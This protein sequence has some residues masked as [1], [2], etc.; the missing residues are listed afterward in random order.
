M[1]GEHAVIHSDHLN[2]MDMLFMY[3][4]MFDECQEMTELFV[5]CKNLQIHAAAQCVEFFFFFFGLR[6]CFSQAAVTKKPSQ[7]ITA[8]RLSHSLSSVFQPWINK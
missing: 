7:Y 2:N 5:C 1:S 6:I 4:D 3:F 8:H